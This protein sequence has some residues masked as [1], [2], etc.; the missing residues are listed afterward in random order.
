M[1]F[2]IKLLS[3]FMAAIALIACSESTTERKGDIR[4]L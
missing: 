2:D 1:K 4:L 3:M